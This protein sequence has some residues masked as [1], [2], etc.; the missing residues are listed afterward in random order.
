MIEYRGYKKYINPLIFQ[1]TPVQVAEGAPDDID[2]ICMYKVPQKADLSNCRGIGH[3][4]KCKAVN[5]QLLVKDLDLS[6]TAVE[7]TSV[8]TRIVQISQILE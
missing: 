6:W 5:L 7:V 3:G 8:L 2:H 1:N 4:V